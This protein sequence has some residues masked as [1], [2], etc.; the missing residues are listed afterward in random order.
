[1]M[2]QRKRRAMG[3]LLAGVLRGVQGGPPSAAARG[4]WPSAEEPKQSVGS[5][6]Q[7]VFEAL[8]RKVGA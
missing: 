6:L 5:L 8:S 3:S 1:M 7:S 2:F 4:A